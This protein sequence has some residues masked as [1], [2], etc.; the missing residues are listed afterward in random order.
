MKYKI[1]IFT[2]LFSQ[3]FHLSVT[4]QN[5][6]A[7]RDEYFRRMEL[8]AIELS[9]KMAELSG[10]EPIEIIKPRAEEVIELLPTD[11]KPP[12]AENTPFSSAGSKVQ[13]SYDALPGPTDSNLTSPSVQYEDKVGESTLFSQLTS[14]ELKGSYYLRPS[15]VL[16]ITIDAEVN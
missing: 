6:K 15:N 8:R 5:G 14:E 11:T 7:D 4:G 12:V 16:Q 10:S 1:V 3:F 2:W 9:R 13:D